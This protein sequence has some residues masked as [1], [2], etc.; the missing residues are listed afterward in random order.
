[1]DSVFSLA[2]NTLNSFDGSLNVMLFREE[3]EP[4]SGRFKSRQRQSERPSLLPVSV[5]VLCFTISY[6]ITF[7]SSHRENCHLRE[8][9]FLPDLKLLPIS[10]TICILCV[11]HAWGPHCFSL[12]LKMSAVSLLRFPILISVGF[13][14]NSLLSVSC[15]PFFW[16]QLPA[17]R[18]REENFLI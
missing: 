15:F 11:T 2:T 18:N 10:H 7:I 9:Y 16:W 3:E 5:G 14:L 13:L 1:M 4:A 8:A 17:W 12:P 6:T